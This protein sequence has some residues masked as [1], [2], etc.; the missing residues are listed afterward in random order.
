MGLIGLTNYYIICVVVAH[1]G[2]CA[3]GEVG[4][5]PGLAV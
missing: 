1:L 4:L 2:K 3:S 5:T